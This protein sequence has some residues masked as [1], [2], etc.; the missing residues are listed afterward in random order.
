MVSRKVLLI[1]AASVQLTWGQWAAPLVSTTTRL[2]QIHVIA[3]RK[4]QPV[5]GLT[6]ADFEVTDNGEPQKLAFFAAEAGT[7]G[8]PPAPSARG[9]FTNRG[10]ATGAVTIIL[11][12][13][14]NNQFMDRAFARDQVLR[15]L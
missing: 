9:T 1:L 11:F 4:G 5:T 8:A 14:L 12:D 15:Y 3:T 13:A 6:Q 2:V 7:P 10:A